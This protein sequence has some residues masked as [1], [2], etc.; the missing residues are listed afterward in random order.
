VAKWRGIAAVLWLILAIAGL[1]APPAAT[2]QSAPPKAGDSAKTPSMAPL[3]DSD[4]K[5]AFLQRHH[6]GTHVLPISQSKLKIFPEFDI[7]LGDQ[8][9]QFYALTNHLSPVA[10]LEAVLLHLPTHSVVYVVTEEA[11]YVALDDWGK[12]DP[13]R[14]IADMRLHSAAA[15]LEAPGLM[16]PPVKVIDWRQKPELD[17]QNAL[18]SWSVDTAIADKPQLQATVLVLTRSGHEK[19]AWVGDPTINPRAILNMVKT[20]LIL[21]PEQRHSDHQ[22]TDRVSSSGV[23]SLVTES[24]GLGRASAGGTTSLEAVQTAALAMVGIS[25]AMFVVAFRLRS[26]KKKVMAHKDA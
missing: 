19:I 15:D 2:A 25:A 14:L 10:S 9:R 22:A 3:D 21:P 17:R 6:G 7:L 16:R 23:T 11:G 13:A 8:A 24:V 26:H 18:I 12:L 5:L 20:A 1:V 4:S